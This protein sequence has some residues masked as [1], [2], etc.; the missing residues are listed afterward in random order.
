MA[1]PNADAHDEGP[2]ADRYEPLAVV[3]DPLK[4]NLVAAQ[5][6]AHGITVWVHGETTGPYPVT[7]GG[8]AQVEIWVDVDRLNEARQ[9][10]TELID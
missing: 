2:H 10:V 3:G 1:E 7:V 8:L 9:I 5:L 4:A 6:R